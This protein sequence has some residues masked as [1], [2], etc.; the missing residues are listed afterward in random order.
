LTAPGCP[1][2]RGNG[3]IDICRDLLRVGSPE[4]GAGQRRWWSAV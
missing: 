3:V 2:E 4:R 1:Q